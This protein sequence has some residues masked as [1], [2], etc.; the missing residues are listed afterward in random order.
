VGFLTVIALLI[1]F[2]IALAVYFMPTIVAAN[3]K[4]SNTTAIF[5][6]DLLLGWTLIG[7][8]V[9]LVWALAQEARPTVVNVYHTADR[10]N[11]LRK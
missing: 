11:N 7:W 1:A 9:A 6:L 2:L 5:V 3:R 8:V 10:D 4:K